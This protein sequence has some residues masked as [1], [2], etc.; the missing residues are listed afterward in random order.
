MATITGQIG[1]NRHPET[2]STDLIQLIC[3]NPLV[4]PSVFEKHSC[5]DWSQMDLEVW[6]KIAAE[7]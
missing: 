2:V 4:N 3:G 1:R 5:A 7:C 6:R